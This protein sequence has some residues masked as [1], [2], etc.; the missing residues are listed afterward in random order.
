MTVVTAISH[1]RNVLLEDGA[2]YPLLWAVLA[3]I[4]DV[5]F[6]RDS[7]PSVGNTFSLAQHIYPWRVN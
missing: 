3:E 6:R 7:H 4:L 2:R 5:L 1:V